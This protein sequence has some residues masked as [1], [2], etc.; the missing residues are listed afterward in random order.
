MSETSFTFQ[1]DEDLKDKFTTAAKEQNRNGEQLLCDFMRD[2]VDQQNAA[3]DHEKWLRCEVQ[4][5]LDAANAGRVVSSEE[6]EA[7]FAARRAETRRKL[8]GSSS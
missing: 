1:V 7:E 5:G 8:A 4:I 2:F 3:A 6:V